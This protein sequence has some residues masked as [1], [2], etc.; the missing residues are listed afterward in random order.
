MPHLNYQK[1]SL[2]LLFKCNLT[3]PHHLFHQLAWPGFYHLSS[4]LLQECPSRC[5]RH[6]LGPVQTVLPVAFRV[7]LLNYK[8]DHVTLLLKTLQEL[9][10]NLRRKSEALTL[11]YKAQYDT[12]PPPLWLRLRPCLFSHWVHSSTPAPLVNS[13]CTKYALG[14]FLCL[15]FPLFRRPFRQRCAWLLPFSSAHFVRGWLLWWT[16]KIVLPC[17]WVPLP[18]LHFLKGSGPLHDFSVSEQVF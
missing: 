15:R 5:P 13:E 4:S 12:N 18:S 14:S 1:L 17:N 16:R 10:I 7:S 8:P 3:T 9:L 11:V 2:A 6:T